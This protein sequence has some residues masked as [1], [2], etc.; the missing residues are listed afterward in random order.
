MVPPGNS[1]RA[2]RN[3]PANPRVPDS[4]GAF[5]QNICV[6]SV[7]VADPYCAVKRRPRNRSPFAVENMNPS[8]RPWPAGRSE[9]Q[10][11]VYDDRRSKTRYSQPGGSLPVFYPNS[12]QALSINRRNQFSVQRIYRILS[13]PIFV[14]EEFHFNSIGQHADLEP[15]RRTSKINAS[16]F[17]IIYPLINQIRRIHRTTSLQTSNEETDLPGFSFFQD[18]HFQRVITS[19]SS[20]TFIDDN[21]HGN[22]ISFARS[23]NKGIVNV[24]I[25][26]DLDRT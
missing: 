18:D 14:H 25:R 3:H 11:K 23:Q 9:V 13:P 7:E 1:C 26:I 17:V 19:G 21:R 16:D 20:A 12:P 5:F 4:D 2:S 22:P 24:T 8:T 10:S 15:L 6:P